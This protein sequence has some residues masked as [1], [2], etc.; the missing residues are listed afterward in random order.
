[1]NSPRLASRAFTLGVAV[2]FFAQTT[3]AADLAIMAGARP[4][5]A[6]QL[7]PRAL[8]MPKAEPARRHVRV[9][10]APWAVTTWAKGFLLDAVSVADWIVSPAEKTENRVEWALPE[11]RPRALVAVAA[12]S[13][14][15]PADSALV[16]P[17]PGGDRILVVR[18]PSIV[19]VAMAL[20]DALA[21]PASYP[22]LLSEETMPRVAGP[23]LQGRGFHYRVVY[24]DSL[25]STVGKDGGFTVTRPGRL[26]A[27]VPA[28][29]PAFMRRA[30][31]IYYHG[32]RARF[33]VEVRADE[34]LAGLRLSFREEE[35]DGRP[36]TP[37]AALG[38]LTLKAKQRGVL[39]GE[40]ILLGQADSGPVNFERTHLV[41]SVAG[42]SSARLDA[43]D[44]GLIDPPGSR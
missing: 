9:E 28:N 5:M 10:S 30:A 8:L 14:L 39:S 43:P 44:A 1:M 20:A 40:T 37:F 4:M 36:L 34:D 13:A 25:G 42:E 24:L 32:M 17:L 22:G 11:R 29:V 19:G 15:R 23:W 26:T 41:A 27:W 2:S 33:Q 3:G 18:D 35:L 6:A 7:P 21:A 12:D 16:T 38:A 31:P